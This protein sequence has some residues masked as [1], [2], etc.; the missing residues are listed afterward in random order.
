MNASTSDHVDLNRE[1]RAALSVGSQPQGCFF[2]A[3]ITTGSS[4]HR[5]HLELEYQGALCVSVDNRVSSLCVC[6]DHQGELSVRVRT[7]RALLQ[8]ALFVDCQESS[9]SVEHREMSESG[10]HQNTR[11]ALF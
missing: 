3:P 7:T 10:P 6:I 4:P 8:G 9:L 11:L 5:E 1:H 2:C